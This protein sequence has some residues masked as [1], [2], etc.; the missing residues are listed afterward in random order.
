MRIVRFDDSLPILVD[1]IG[2]ALGNEALQAGTVLRDAVGC[3]A[4]FASNPLDKETVETLSLKLR[5]ALGVYARPDRAVAGSEDS[6]S[7]GKTA[8]AYRVLQS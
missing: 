1:M 7:G 3:L 5:T 2:S 6:G 8:A 4:F